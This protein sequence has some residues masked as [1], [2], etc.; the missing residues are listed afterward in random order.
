M[1]HVRGQ[2]ARRRRSLCTLRTPPTE[3]G[4]IH[5]T[6]NAPR[7]NPQRRLTTADARKTETVD[8]IDSLRMVVPACDR[9]SHIGT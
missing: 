1:T 6:S 5:M 3:T 4:S 7:S 8:A 2:W 9:H